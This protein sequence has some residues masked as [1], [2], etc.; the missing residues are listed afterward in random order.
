MLEPSWQRL[1]QAVR[2][3]A[4]VDRLLEAQIEAL[5]GILRQGREG[6]GLGGIT[7]GAAAAA[8]TPA[9]CCC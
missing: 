1:E 6:V 5:D 7:D 9:S 3:A 8:A 4:E 2:E